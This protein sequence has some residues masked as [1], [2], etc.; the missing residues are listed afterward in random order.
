MRAFLPFL[1]VLGAVCT[2][3]SAMAELLDDG[4]AAYEQR[5]FPLARETLAPI[6]AEGNA[7]A[8]LILGKMYLTG[9][10]VPLN[11]L[12]ASK[13]FRRAA[14]QGNAEAQARLGLLYLRGGG[15]RQDY[16]EAA[17]WLRLAAGQGNTEAQQCLAGLYATGE[18][19][20]E[21]R[22][23]AHAWYSLAAVDGTMAAIRDRDFLA[24]KLTPEELARSAKLQ[25]EWSPGRAPKR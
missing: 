2:P 12:I 25:S 23:A 4:V 10:G 22:A 15:V 13:W 24:A 20:P 9:Q 6:A 16:R 11:G 3:F 1:V 21:D 5:N 14:D 17:Q 18:G 19:V 7:K 8:Q